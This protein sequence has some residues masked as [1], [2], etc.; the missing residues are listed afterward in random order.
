MNSTMSR[1]AARTVQCPACGAKPGERCR[2]R[3]GE[4]E[5]NHRERVEA[6]EVAQERQAIIARGGDPDRDWGAGEL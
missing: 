6:A 2:G 1:T 5:S 4:R 3:R